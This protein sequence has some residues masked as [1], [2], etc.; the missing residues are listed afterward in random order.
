MAERRVSEPPMDYIAE[1]KQS[2]IFEEQDYSEE[3]IQ[4]QSQSHENE[5]MD[6][7]DN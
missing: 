7:E 3:M 2:D 4:A 6:N 5:D 1:R